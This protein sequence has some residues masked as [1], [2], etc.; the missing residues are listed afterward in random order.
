MISF[1]VDGPAVWIDADPATWHRP[2]TFSLGAYGLT[3]A[4][5]R[6]LDVLDEFDVKATFFVPGWIAE[7][8][9]DRFR[10]IV[11]RG[12]EMGHH[13]YLHELYYSLPIP[14]Q[15]ELI[16]RSQGVFERVAGC[17]ARGFRG[18][19]GD[20]REGTPE[21]LLEL[22]FSYSSSM[23][24]DDRPY[25]WEVGGQPSELIE[26]PAHWELDDFP[27]LGYHDNPA[28]PIGLDRIAGLD[29]T[30]D[31]W[32]REFDGYYRYGLCYPLMLHP[33]VI[34]KP[35]RVEILRT[36]LE[37]IRARGDV[38]VATGAEIADWWRSTY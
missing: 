24:G 22:G 10:S 23:R 17:R 13:G 5:P 32:L 38:W 2:A 30:L 6:L 28:D 37:R 25:R 16:E 26:I 19:S 34:G 18:P 15:R 14:E 4:V 29:W 27:Q 9:P 33:Q 3:R 11:A 31:N 8:W 21:L 1:D 36:L 7:A 20:I 35:G 12:H